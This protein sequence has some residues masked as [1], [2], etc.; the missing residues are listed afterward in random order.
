MKS[1]H[2]FRILIKKRVPTL[3]IHKN[4]NIKKKRKY[5]KIFSYEKENTHDRVRRVKKF[6]N[7]G[8]E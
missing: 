3:I 5:L 6:K 8:V 4:I 2:K 1:T 7:N